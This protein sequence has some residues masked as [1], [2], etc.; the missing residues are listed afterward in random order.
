ML[1]F[2]AHPGLVGQKARFAKPCFVV[3]LLPAK[4]G[5]AVKPFTTIAAIIFALMALLHAYR[6]ATDFQVVAGSHRI[7]YEVSWVGLAV[8][9]V[10][11]WGLF[12]ESRR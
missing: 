8:A 10:L 9:A 3:R 4:G 12:R 1:S 5:K 11:A 7:P 6:L 2:P